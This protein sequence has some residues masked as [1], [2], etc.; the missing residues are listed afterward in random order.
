MASQDTWD[1]RFSLILYPCFAFL[2][3][4]LLLPFG[5]FIG[6][7]GVYYARAG[8]NLVAGRGIAANVGEPYTIHPP[9]YPFLIGLSNLLFKNLE[10]SGHFVSIL[11]FAL[12]L[13]PVFLLA[14]S[15]YPDLS[16]H[17]ASL[18]YLTN[19][20]LLI[21]SNLV[22]TESLFT[23]LVMTQFY[24]IHQVIQRK[25]RPFFH[26]TLLGALA[27]LA[28]LTRP[29]GLFFYAVGVLAILLLSSEPLA[30]K[31]RVIF[32]SLIPFLLCFLA[33][34]FFV[35][36]STGQFQL[37]GGV[38]EILIKRQLDVSHPE[39]YLEVKKIY[40]GL[41][42][43][44]TRLKME[45]L[46][47]GFRL[48]TYLTKDHFALLHSAI[49]SLLARLMELNPYL[50]AG[51]GFFLIGASF[52]SIPWRP[53]R[54]KSEILLLLFMLTFLPQT[55]GTFLPKRFYH[56]FPIFLIWMGQGMERIRHWARETFQ[57]SSKAATSMV[58]G[59]CVSLALLSGGYLHRVLASPFLPFEYKTMGLWMKQNLPHLEEE[60]VASRQ[61]AVSFYSG[62]KILKLPYV[63][64][65]EDLLIFM[66]HQKAKYF[67]LSEDLDSPFLETYRPLLD[68]TRPPP[69]GLIR[70]H[71][72]D[73]RKKAILYEIIL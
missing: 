24:I 8:F 15:I 33:N 43:D 17:W 57:L 23:L 67:V 16:A 28:L 13:I 64:K 65:L 55:I 39:Q 66:S 21:H 69:R 41:T 2:A 40:E 48:L 61:P 52:F 59:V 68:E 45:E 51:F 31:S 34:L 1:S 25:S 42:E 19:G 11:A 36:Q 27:G 12:T 32:F 50:F 38:T 26:G 35:Y 3:S 22:M 10:F 46:K 60:R 70:K 47:E 62:A 20:Y 63:D 37:S 54:K 53:E 4:L 14:K 7:D 18:L 71:V 5:Y 9:F 72:V 44:K 6:D 29:E 73:G 49:P 56:Y 30:S 58:L